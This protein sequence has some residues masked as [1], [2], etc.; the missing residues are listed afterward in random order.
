MTTFDTISAGSLEG[1]RRQQITA[2]LQALQERREQLRVAI[3]AQQ[4]QCR[5]LL[6]LGSNFSYPF[7]A[8]RLLVPPVPQAEQHLI[9]P[10]D[11]VKR[12]RPVIGKRR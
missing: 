12:N 4:Q 2:E 3:A 6:G 8:S 9:P 7:V 10:R 1:T 5:E 11:S